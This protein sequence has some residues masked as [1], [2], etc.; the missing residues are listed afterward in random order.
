METP[1]GIH[2]H[3]TMKKGLRLQLPASGCRKQGAGWGKAGTGAP[4]QGAGNRV[5]G[6]GLLHAEPEKGGLVIRCKFEADLTV[7]H[8]RRF[9]IHG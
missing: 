7:D 9:R 8:G 4:H 5:R 2:V 3:R 1:A 6:G